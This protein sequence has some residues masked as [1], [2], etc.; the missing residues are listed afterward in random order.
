MKIRTALAACCVTAALGTLAACSSSTADS[1]ASAAPTASSSAAGTDD[2]TALCAQ[3]VDQK[4]PVEAAE[5]LAEGSGY[6][7]RIGSVDGKPKAL[8]MDYREDRMTFAV[9]DGPSVRRTQA[10]RPASSHP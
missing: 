8:T 2:V 3:V 4:M 5:A 6:Q 1:S 7:W 9:E 10:A